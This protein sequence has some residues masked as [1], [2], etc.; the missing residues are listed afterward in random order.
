MATAT[1]L[2][3]EIP[4]VPEQITGDWLSQELALLEEETRHPGFLYASESGRIWR[5]G[6]EIG[7]EEDWGERRFFERGAGAPEEGTTENP[8]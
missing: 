3:Q 4:T 7:Q 8:F 5:R 1:V 2:I 6:E